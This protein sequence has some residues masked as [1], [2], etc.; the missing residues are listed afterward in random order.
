MSR[1]C[2]TSRWKYIERS[3]NTVRGKKPRERPQKRWKDSIKELLDK[4]GAD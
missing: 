3:N 4:S 2:I 1:P